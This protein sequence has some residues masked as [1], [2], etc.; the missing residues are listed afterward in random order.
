MKQIWI[1][2]FIGCWVGFTAGWLALGLL[3]IGRD[4]REAQKIL[5]TD[6]KSVPK[7]GGT[8]CLKK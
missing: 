3:I 4:L 5:G 2:F 7:T 1:V 6:L 8:Q